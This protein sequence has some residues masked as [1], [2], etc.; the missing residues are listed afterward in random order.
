[1]RDERAGAGSTSTRLPAALRALRHRDYRL[2][3]GGQLVSLSGTWM[4]SVAQAWLVYRLTGSAVLL[5]FVSFSGQIPVFMLAP[6]GGAAADRY[7]RRRIL[8]FTQ[9]AS[10][11][12]AL[13][14]A[15]LTL[16]GAVRVWHVF[17]LA[18]MVGVVNAF[19][20]PARQSFVVDMVGKEDLVNAIALN[21]SMFN[22]ARIVGPAVAGLLVAAVGEGW[23]F[24]ANGVSYAAVIA[25]LALMRVG[26]VARARPP[27]S[28]F[29]RIRAG[30]RFVARTGPVRA[31]MLL[32][33]LVSLTGMPYAVLMPIFAD[34]ILGGGPGGLGLLMGASGAGALTGA[35]V[36]AS[37]RSVRGL[38]RWVAWAS[39]AFGVSLILFSMSR[40]FWLS[41]ALLVPAGFSMIV[42]MAS[43]NT[44][45]QS[46]VPDELRGRVMAVHSMMFMGMAPVGALLAG[47][48]AGRLGAPLTVAL[49]GAACVAG[50]A[51]FW[52]RI[53]LHRGEARRLIVAQQMSG[54]TPPEEV[55]DSPESVSG[56][57]FR[58][59]SSRQKR[60]AAGGRELG[61]GAVER[62][63]VNDRHPRRVLRA[64]DDL[65]RHL[66]VLGRVFEPHAPLPEV[67]Q[68][69]VDGEAVQPGRERRVAAEHPGLAQELDEDLLREVF[70]L[71]LVLHHAQAQA[72][73][74]PVVLP[75]ELLV[76]RR[77]AGRGPLRQ[78]VVGRARRL[79]F[80]RRFDPDRRPLS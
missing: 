34:R 27:G 15:A 17:T 46:M 23:C 40:S 43:S 76:G 10:M 51:L 41:A 80:R 4:Q 26:R 24:F 61:D 36:L 19:D 72:V 54:G 33:G 64:L 73:D 28:A 68:D 13:A 53:P 57:G 31:L 62:D 42:Q 22:G 49:G 79:H 11:V 38:G 59:S 67:H 32:L 63:A 7:P 77:V 70:G 39:A 6:L 48:L 12:L 50:A 20:I 9:A 71:G 69:L 29:E 65:L 58:V 47:A 74:A 75:V 78:L 14:L 18:A 45:I 2:F 52:R 1:M 35:V 25:G 56:S 8:I 5:G 66:A 37:R 16:G 55:T 60:R 3:F 30:F 44:L 21:S